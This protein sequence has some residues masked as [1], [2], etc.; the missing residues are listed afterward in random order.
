MKKKII[1]LLLILLILPISVKAEEGYLYDVM[2][3]KFNDGL[4]VKEYTGEHKDSMSGSNDKKIYHFYAELNFDAIQV[5]DSNN[6]IFGEQC[7]QILRTTDNG[8]VRLIYNGEAENNQCLGSRGKH[9]GYWYSDSIVPTEPFY[10]GTDY[11]YNKETKKFRITGN[12]KTSDGTLENAL[13]LVGYYTCGSTDPNA[14]CSEILYVTSSYFYENTQKIYI[15]TR[16]LGLFL[17]YYSIGVDTFSREKSITGSS[18]MFKH[19]EDFIYDKNIPRGTVYGNDFT[20][21]NGV[22]K[23]VDTSTTL[24]KNHHYSCRSMDPDA[25]CEILLYY[26]CSYDSTSSYY[27]VLKNGEKPQE[28]ISALINADILEKEDSKVKL[29]IDEWYKHNLIEFEDNL[30]KSAIYCEDKSISDFQAFNPNGGNYYYYDGI[31]DFDTQKDNYNTIYCSN[32]SDRYSYDN[33]KAK[34]KYPIAIPNSVEMKLLESDRLRTV[35]NSYWTL[36]PSG[37]SSI[38]NVIGSSVDSYGKIGRLN[39]D[40]SGMIRPVVTLKPN[41]KYISGD[42]SETSPFI[43]KPVIYSSIAVLDEEERGNVDVQVE[44]VEK[45]EEDSIVRFSINPK[46]GFVLGT[47]KIT[48]EEGNEIQFTQ[49]GNS[50]EFIMPDSKVNII[51]SYEALIVINPETGQISLLFLTLVLLLSGIIGITLY[52]KQINY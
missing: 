16:K 8:G 47:V 19:S 30:D 51:P 3:Q 43:I 13:S 9:M 29:I 14:T 22:Y 28:K 35:N 7:W 38:Y 42:G 12:T 5:L 45:I 49:T 17:D 48:D 36:N 23:L 41:T 34:L 44:N 10:Y 25:T 32:I 24:D 11:V 33:P 37:F 26:Y 20:Y 21:E 39:T 18:Y 31:F 52:K 15:N 50:F 1:S 2:E 27:L 6:V 4:A 40:S 46:L